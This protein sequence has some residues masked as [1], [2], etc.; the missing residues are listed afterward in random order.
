MEEGVEEATEPVAPTARTGQR[1][2]QVE[3]RSRAPA[4]EGKPEVLTMGRHPYL[5]S[6]VEEAENPERRIH[7][8]V[9]RLLA[10]LSDLPL[11]QQADEA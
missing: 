9:R 11:E 4:R 3:A 7:Q 10:R 6:H 1:N 2:E 5:G 8:E